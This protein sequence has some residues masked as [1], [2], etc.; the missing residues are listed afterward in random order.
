MA[1]CAIGTDKKEP[2][3]PAKLTYSRW[4]APGRVSVYA[5]VRE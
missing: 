3:C 5:I 1:L 4:F 2:S